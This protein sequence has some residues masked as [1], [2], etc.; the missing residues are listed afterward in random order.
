[1]SILELLNNIEE[2]KIRYQNEFINKLRNFKKVMLWGISES[3]INAIEFLNKNNINVAGIYDNDR[4]KNN[5]SF[6]NLKV[7]FPDDDVYNLDVALVITCSYYETLRKN[8]IVKEKNIDKRL[9]M[10]DGYF[11]ENKDLSYYL[12]N[13]E[14]IERC[15]KTFEDKKSKN[16]YLKLLKYRYIRDINLLKDLYDSRLE[17]YLDKAFLDSFK[18][19]VYVDAG[20]YNADFITS[21]KERKNIDNCFFY[22]FEPNKIFSEKIKESLN[23]KYNYKLFNLALC[24]KEGE[25]EFQQIPSST[26]H[27]TDKKYNAYN[28]TLE[29]NLELVKTNTLD[30]IL[31]DI[32]VKGIKIDIEG[33]EQAMLNGAVNVIKRDRPVLLISVYH[34]WNDLWEI[35]DFINNMDLNYKFYLRHYSLSVA[36]T[37]LYC[38]PE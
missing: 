33:S 30:N 31:K 29:C 22:I 20:S 35:Q 7:I 13:K 12:D 28:D 5:T 36:K 14:I 37:I 2:E 9:F 34:R 11:L 4:E 8:L 17:C 10:Y 38:I 1:M 3:A 27:L 25:L 23:D 18:E 26:S 24:D 32:N 6:L 15:Y 21:L 16:L 19:G